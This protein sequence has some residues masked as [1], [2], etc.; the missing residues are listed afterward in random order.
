MQGAGRVWVSPQAEHDPMAVRVHMEG[1]RLPFDS[2]LLRYLPEVCCL[3]RLL[4]SHDHA[5]ISLNLL[6]QSPNGALFE[7]KLLRVIKSTAAGY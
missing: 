5:S 3:S 7:H 4:E 6:N 2:L 1:R